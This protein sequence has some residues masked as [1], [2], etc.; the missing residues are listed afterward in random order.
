MTGPHAVILAGGLGTRLRPLTT[1]IPKPLVPIGDRHSIID[2][3]IAQLAAAGFEEIRIAVGHLSHLIKA[4]IG[5]GER[6]G[7]RIRYIEETTPLGTAGPLTLAEGLPAHFLVMNGDVLCDID[8]RAMLREHSEENRLLT[9]AAVERT[10]QHE[11]GVLQV[12]DSR[13]ISFGEKPVESFLVSTGVYV[14]AHAAVAGYDRESVLGFDT[15][16]QDLI[17]RGNPPH[18]Y[19]HRGHWFDVGRPDDYDTVNEHA[20]DLLGELLPDG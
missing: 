20:A 15:L 11:Y 13:L 16:I 3:A 2:V 9:V 7:T 6:W 18:V 4:T 10:V 12:Q 8:Y 19:L 5:D 1:L 14:V 17:E